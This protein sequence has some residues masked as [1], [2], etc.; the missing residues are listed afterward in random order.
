MDISKVPTH[1]L[2]NLI[3]A[4]IMHLNK[5]VV[6]H[7]EENNNKK[8]DELINNIFVYSTDAEQFARTDYLSRR[9]ARRHCFDYE[10]D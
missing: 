6:T 4:V 1:T 9:F 3:K 7:G 8:L 2:T 10:S 5:E